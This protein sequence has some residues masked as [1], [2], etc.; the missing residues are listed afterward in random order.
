MLIT[1]LH[2]AREVASLQ[3]NIYLFLKVLWEIQNGN[4]FYQYYIR[5]AS[6]YIVPFVNIDGYQ[7]IAKKMSE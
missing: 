2:H 1:S 6:I 7:L 5:T 3:M 4:V